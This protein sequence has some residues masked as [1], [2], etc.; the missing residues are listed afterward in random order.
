[1]TR[2]F[3]L[4]KVS[5]L[6]DITTL[7]LHLPFL[8]ISLIYVGYSVKIS[9]GVI[10]S[11]L[12]TCF[13][14]FPFGLVRSLNDARLWVVFAEGLN[15]VSEFLGKR[16]GT[17]ICRKDFWSKTPY[18]TWVQ[19][20]QNHYEHRCTSGTYRA[21]SASWAWPERLWI[22]WVWRGPAVSRWSSEFLLLQYNTKIWQYI[23]RYPRKESVVR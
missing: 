3:D 14:V 2:S 10:Q 9:R 21:Y 8:Q 20:H 18:A 17:H 1:M 16:T 19:A 7:T 4:S 13:D 6:L 12:E 5:R 11:L 15:L 23:I 22:E